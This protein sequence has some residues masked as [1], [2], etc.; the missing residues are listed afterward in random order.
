MPIHGATRGAIFQAAA[1]LA[2]VTGFFLTDVCEAQ[3]PAAPSRK[4]VKLF[5]AP[6]PMGSPF[7]PV[8]PVGNPPGAAPMAIGPAPAPG[9]FFYGPPPPVYPAVIYPPPPYMVRRAS[10]FDAATPGIAIPQS[11]QSP[12]FVERQAVNSV[13][14][15]VAP[16]GNLRLTVSESFLNR[17]VARD[18]QKPGPVRDFIL[19]ADVIGRQT[20]DTKV[21]LD[22]LPSNEVIKAAIVLNGVTQS[23][24]TGVT[25]QA[26]VD[27]AG[28]QQ[29]R[30]VKEIY[31]DG[32]RFS[33]RHAVVLARA[34]NQTM[35][36]KT[37]LTGTVLGGIADRIAF[38]AAEKRQA[39]GEA[40][41]RDKVAGRV[42][43]EFDNG[44]DGQL[45][46][47]NDQL[48]EKV[49][50]LLRRIDL[51]PLQQQVTSTDTNLNYSV[52]IGSD[53]PASS[54]SPLEAQI[55]NEDSIGLLIHESLLNTLVAKAG[56]K[57]LKTTDQQIKEM[58]SPYELKFSGD[59]SDLSP[60]KIELP[61]MKTLVT[62]IEFDESDPLTI[63]LEKDRAVVT[64]RA[65]FKPGGQD[66]LPP[67]ALTIEYKTAL[68]G[69]K[70]V[71]SPG[72][73]QVALVNDADKTAT[74]G[75][76]LRLIS[77]AVE[78]S[79]SKLAVDRSLPAS[80]W[81]FGGAVPRVSGIQTQ[82][83]WAVVTVN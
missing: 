77:Q 19:G 37:P 25:P 13:V 58:M 71:V 26:M 3:P 55:A 56:L 6:A 33:T 68:E 70:I 47:A 40:I 12:S 66:V 17:F 5:I 34:H 16:M 15:T 9:Q 43:P 83:G 8:G 59:D 76:A 49:R 39:E 61:G 28:Q 63:R 2:G 62:T 54:A 64:I 21:R 44:I 36:A 51:M 11:T 22:L 31:F 78:A 14:S 27:T 38:R 52:Q 53:S 32:T 69:E 67:L 45:A 73:V 50:P 80:L 46:K 41:A 81:T 72:K 60:P 1:M 57:G 42:F 30:A 10:P 74:S 79:L 20:T 75:I 24:T 29:F 23:L 7:V 35:G 65:T 18:E 82:D 48:E 4:P